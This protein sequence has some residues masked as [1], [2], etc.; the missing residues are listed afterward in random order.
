[1]SDVE[2]AVS[3]GAA[4]RFQAGSISKQ[5]VAATAMLLVE[6]NE[7][8]LHAPIGRWLLQLP[9]AWREIT[10]HQLLSHSS[11][12]GHWNDLERVN[13][14]APLA[15]AELVDLAASTPLLF[16]PGERFHYSGLGYLLVAR[17]VQMVAHAPYDTFVRDQLLVPAGLCE[18]TSGQF[19]VGERDVA[20]GYH[21]G[22]EVEVSAHLSRLIGTGDL[23]TTVG[24]LNHWT[25]SMYAAMLLKA[26]SVA[27]MMTKQIDVRP[28]SAAA[29]G[30]IVTTGYG[31]G[32]RLGTMLGHAALFHT[33]DNP[34]YSSLVAWLPAT[35]TTIAVL[36]NDD[37]RDLAEPLEQIVAPAL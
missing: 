15:E 24:D 36:T 19:P 26:N 10:P 33:G 37:G 27:T 17:L 34:G 21:A 5:F 20:L 11:G 35:A 13:A 28:P 29:H 31:Y 16:P 22:A 8:K 14:E 12:L 1:M 32:T 3:C 25:S 23:W 4:T 9:A 2:A 6:R 30:L 18:T 7:L